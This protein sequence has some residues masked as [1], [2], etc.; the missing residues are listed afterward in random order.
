MQTWP[1]QR[2]LQPVGADEA[3][4]RDDVVHFYGGANERYPAL[5]D[6]GGSPDVGNGGQLTYIA[7]HA[8]VHTIGVRSRSGAACST[9]YLGV[10]RMRA[11]TGSQI[12]PSINF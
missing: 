12:P 8:G 7:R 4:T 5:M 9:Y 6:R 10:T 2:H 11:D 1:P 3:C